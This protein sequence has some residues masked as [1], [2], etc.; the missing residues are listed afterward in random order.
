MPARQPVPDTWDDLPQPASMYPVQPD[1]IS[2]ATRA[3][4]GKV[5]NIYSPDD[6]VVAIG[7]TSELLSRR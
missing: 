5:F 1:V 3:C 6:L 2:R 4:A 7:K